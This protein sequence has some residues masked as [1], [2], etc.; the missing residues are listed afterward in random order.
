MRNAIC[1]AL[2]LLAILAGCQTTTEKPAK[3]AEKPAEP[4]MAHVHIGHVMTGW[5]DTPDKHGLLPT[6][7]AEA[8][9][10]ARYADAAL[11][12]PGDL[13]WMKTN[14]ANVMHAID[15]SVQATGP[16]LGYGVKI[17]AEGA[18]K[19]AEFAAASEGASENVKENAEYVKTSARNAVLWSD[20]ILT[21]GKRVQAAQSAS[22]AIRSVRRIKTMADAL[23]G[24]I[25]ADGN[26]EI[27]WHKGEG[28]LGTAEKYMGVMMKK[29][30]LAQG[31]TGQ[32]SQGLSR[33]A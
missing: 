25:D 16:G 5:H 21:L 23:I 8:R 32:T 11:Q 29:E 30:H 28:G 1:L 20:L 10:A 4:Q 2:V 24:G 27:T 17:A 3:M 13:Q 31:N 18:A 26:G 33:A 15:P 6:A 12:K 9:I 22:D 14:V 19:H 7:I